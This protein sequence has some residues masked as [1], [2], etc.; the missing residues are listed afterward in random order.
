MGFGCW[1]NRGERSDPTAEIDCRSSTPDWETRM[2]ALRLEA[3]TK[4]LE[5]RFNADTG[6]M[7]NR[8]IHAVGGLVCCIL[9]SATPHPIFAEVSGLILLGMGY[10]IYKP[11]QPGPLEK[12]LMAEYTKGTEQS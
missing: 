3:L 11:I 9:A 12:E 6:Q 5:S 1:L 4:V 2:N 10:L 8:N 7:I